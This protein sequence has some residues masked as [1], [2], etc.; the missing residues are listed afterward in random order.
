MSFIS[1]RKFYARETAR[2]KWLSL[3]ALVL[4]LCL[5]A[6]TVAC[7]S[8]NGPDGDSV[9]S[10]VPDSSRQEAEEAPDDPGAPSQKEQAGTEPT[11]AD[12][13]REIGFVPDPDMTISIQLLD[14]EINLDPLQ[15]RNG[16]PVDSL[17]GCNLVY[18][19]LLKWDP[20]ELTYKPGLA[21]LLGVSADGI[22]LKIRENAVW[23]D[24]RPVTPEQIELSLYWMCKFTESCREAEGLVTRVEVETDGEIATD[25]I[26]LTLA[27]SG[28][29]YQA[30]ALDLLCRAPIMPANIWCGGKDPLTIT[31]EEL[32]IQAD[33]QPLGT[34]PWQVKLNDSFQLVLE[35]CV[36][37]ENKPQYLMLR[38]YKDRLSK[39]RAFANREIDIL[40]GALPDDDENYDYF[41]GRPVLSGIVVKRDHYLFKNIYFRNLLQLAVDTSKT[42]RVL[43]SK[44]ANT[45]F[46][47]YFGGASLVNRLRA[48]LSNPVFADTYLAHKAEIA[49]KLGGT[50]DSDGLLRLEQQPIATLSLILP[51]D[52]QVEAA[53]GEFAQAA[54]RQGLK[55]E[56]VILDQAAYK[57]RVDNRDY[58]LCY[59]QT[60]EKL[61]TPFSLAQDFLYH[62]D[63]DDFEKLATSGLS[64]QVR[65]LALALAVADTANEFAAAA[66]D[67]YQY[68][69]QQM[70]FFPLGFRTINNGHLNSKYWH[71]LSAYWATHLDSITID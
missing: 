11:Q 38:K 71:D 53:C 2:S 28:D 69:L 44:A 43:D 49:A 26:F 47:H 51:D 42:G 65:T 46:W 13:F 58:D 36:A 66:K 59:I 4:A 57:Q 48:D 17:S 40:G 64:K 25:R 55:L 5:L 30:L 68:S 32:Q 23:H 61:E 35:R 14:D 3:P 31:E 19:T 12:V 56:L 34:G 8:G 15:E 60:T 62:L 39:E 29:Y 21:E 63:R 52:P 41:A 16:F 33:R 9:P 37:A 20:E 45:I 24:G 1:A 7:T 22:K 10:T 50:W 27:E 67:C 18:E 6:G 54:L 70:Q